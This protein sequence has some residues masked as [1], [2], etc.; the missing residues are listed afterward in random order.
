[1]HLLKN[2]WKCF[3][4]LICQSC[5]WAFSNGEHVCIH[6]WVSITSSVLAAID[7]LLSVTAGTWWAERRHFL[8]KELLQHSIFSTCCCSIFNALHPSC[9]RKEFKL[10][11]KQTKKHSF[12]F[13]PCLLRCYVGVCFMKQAVALLSVW[14]NAKKRARFSIKSPSITLYSLTTQWQTYCI[15]KNVWIAHKKFGK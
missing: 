1:M 9:P 15:F 3:W 4:W 12:L 14:K 2:Q 13:K 8:G 6:W 11:N 5:P 7:F 10:K